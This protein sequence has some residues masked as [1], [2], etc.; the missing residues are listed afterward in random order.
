MPS[1]RCPSASKRV[2][3]PSHV[4]VCVCVYMPGSIC[5]ARTDPILFEQDDRS[6]IRA[7]QRTSIASRD[8]DVNSN[9]KS[10]GHSAAASSPFSPLLDAPYVMPGFPHTCVCVWVF[11]FNTH[12][13]PFSS[14]NFPE[15]CCCCC[16]SA[17]QCF[18]VWVTF[19][20]GGCKGVRGRDVRF[21]PT[22]REAI[23][24]AHMQA[25]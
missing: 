4:H 12:V 16:C 9:A 7:A 25:H 6:S 13:C 20:E 17:V 23:S 10:I 8:I 18:C 11:V 19:R 21:V 24:G 15:F 22:G 1:E 5:P 3:A 2:H 14:R